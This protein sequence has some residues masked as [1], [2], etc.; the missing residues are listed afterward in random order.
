MRGCRGPLRCRIPLSRPGNQL[1][2][3]SISRRTADLADQE[4]LGLLHSISIQTWTRFLELTEEHRFPELDDIVFVT[5]HAELVLLASQNIEGLVNRILIWQTESRIDDLRQYWQEHYGERHETADRF[6]N[7]LVTLAVVMI[8]TIVVFLYRLTAVG[9]RIQM[10][11]E[12]LEKRVAAPPGNS[13][14]RSRFYPTRSRTFR[15][16]SRSGIATTA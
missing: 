2:I 3:L 9:L 5:R 11:N 4:K 10:L 8:G 6:G 14:P 15:K 16:A 1:D 12:S 7:Y 13:K